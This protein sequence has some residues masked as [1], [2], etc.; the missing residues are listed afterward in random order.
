MLNISFLR[1]FEAGL[2]LAATWVGNL[3]SLQSQLLEVGSIQASP[4]A[5]ESYFKFSGLY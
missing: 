1:L 4:H 3:P 5:Q 2:R